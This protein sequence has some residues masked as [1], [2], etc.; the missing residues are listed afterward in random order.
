MLWLPFALAAPALWALSNLVDGQLVREHCLDALTLAGL[1]AV[2]SGLPAL[3]LLATANVPSLPDA[4]TI[5]LAIAAAVAGLLVYLPYYAAL[6]HSSTT[7]VVVLWNLSPAFV[8][9][10]AAAFFREDLSLPEYG[11][12]ASLIAS[13]VL[14]TSS[15]ARKPAG[16]RALLFMT[17]ASILLAVETL[18]LEAVY[19]NTSFEQ[20]LF[21][22]SS[23]SLALG[24][25]LILAHRPARRTLASAA[26]RKWLILTANQGLDA[27]AVVSLGRA[28][29]LGSASMVKAV[30]GLQPLFVLAFAVLLR[31]RLALAETVGSDSW[32]KLRVATAGI[33]GAVGLLLL[34]LGGE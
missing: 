29:S 9:V 14:A 12:I 18:A 22:V 10:G 13:S 1:A 26:P 3:F 8:A 5:T 17:I 19:S 11:A 6:N 32:P 7:A 33:A 16:T 27:A 28:V 34:H 20:G 4:G 15:G 23:A 30:G 21:L 31:R 2:F 25:T 24:V